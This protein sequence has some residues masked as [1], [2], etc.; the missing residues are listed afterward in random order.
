MAY[1]PTSYE[2]MKSQMQDMLVPVLSRLS[3]MEFGAGS[4]TIRRRKEIMEYMPHLQVYNTWGA[5]N[6]AV[7]FSV[8]LQ[9]L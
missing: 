8:M 3:F 2:V 1:V 4:L 6:Q 5:L 9:R 7:Q